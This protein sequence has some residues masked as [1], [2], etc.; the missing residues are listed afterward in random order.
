MFMG[1]IKTLLGIA[2]SP[3]VA[4]VLFC[5]GLLCAAAHLIALPALFLWERHL[6]RR[7]LAPAPEQ[8]NSPR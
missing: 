5:I 7:P 2:A 8:E 6:E 3:L 1:I 4:T